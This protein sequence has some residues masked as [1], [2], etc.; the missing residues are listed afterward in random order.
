MKGTCIP[1]NWKLKR[2]GRREVLKDT[3]VGSPERV[4]I[5]DLVQKEELQASLRRE[6]LLLEAK[7]ET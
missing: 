6:S 7:L 4:R 2:D 1:V 5:E 3:Q